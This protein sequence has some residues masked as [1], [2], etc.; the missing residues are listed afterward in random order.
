MAR[1]EFGLGS[2]ALARKHVA[3][4]RAHLER[5]QAITRDQNVT[6]L[7]TKIEGVLSGI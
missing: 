7:L 3:A 4:A 5:A 2:I 6:M 1:I